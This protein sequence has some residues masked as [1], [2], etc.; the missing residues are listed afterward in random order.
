MGYIIVALIGQGTV[1]YQL[2]IG[3]S[4]RLPV[5]P[6]GPF[7]RPR[8]HYAVDMQDAIYVTDDHTNVKLH[9]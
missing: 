6:T 4:R 9:R 7:G 2:S 3:D 8:S 5:D 1:Q